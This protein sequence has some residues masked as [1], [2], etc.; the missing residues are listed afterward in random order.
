M[1]GPKQAGNRSRSLNDLITERTDHVAED[2]EEETF[3]G[4]YDS[5]SKQRVPSW[6][7]RIIYKSNVQPG[8]ESDD[9]SHI[10]YRSRFPSQDFASDDSFYAT[11]SSAVS[12]HIES[13]SP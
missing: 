11:L 2:K 7:D 10:G 9:E 5:S 8:D 6:C 1:S 3:K 12:Y 4:V 13:R